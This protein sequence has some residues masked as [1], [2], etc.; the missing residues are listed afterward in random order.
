M[1][2]TREEAVKNFYKKLVLIG[3]IVERL[4]N[5]DKLVEIK[6]K[7]HKFYLGKLTRK[8]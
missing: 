1:H 3:R 5:E 8:S 4:K 7:E 6:F 2:P